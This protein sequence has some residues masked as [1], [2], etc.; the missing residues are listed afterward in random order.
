M[1]EGR[2]TNISL[3][4][5]IFDEMFTIIEKREEFDEVTIQKLKELG[6]R[7]ELQKEKKV[8]KVLIPDRGD[9]SETN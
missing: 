3:V 8:S 2:I 7:K 9:E 6:A 1:T 5:Q 4:E